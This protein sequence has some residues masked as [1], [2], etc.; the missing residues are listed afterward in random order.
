MTLTNTW[1]AAGVESTVS[2]FTSAGHD[3]YPNIH[4]DREVL[5]SIGDMALGN[6]VYTTE[7]LELKTDEYGRFLQRTDILP[8][9][10]TRADR[11][12]DGYI[13]ELAYREGV[14]DEITNKLE[15]EVCEN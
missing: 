10:R 8:N 11:N 9:H 13:F 5:T 2:D 3:T 14:Y 12:L 15:D 6:Y 4:I 7:Y 1:S